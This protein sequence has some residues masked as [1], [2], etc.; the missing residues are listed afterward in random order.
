MLARALASVELAAGWALHVVAVFLVR[1]T[2]A[3]IEVGSVTGA[4]LHITSAQWLA[5]PVGLAEV[6]ALWAFEV[7][8]LIDGLALAGVLVLLKAKEAW[9]LVGALLLW[10]ALAE[11]LVPVGIVGAVFL[12]ALAVV[13][14]LALTLV[15]V[16]LQA[17]EVGA[18]LL[19]SIVHGHAIAPLLVEEGAWWAAVNLAP[20]IAHGH[21][22]AFLEVGAHHLLLGAVHVAV[23]L[24]NTLASPLIEHGA[25]W[26]VLPHE[27][28]LAT[29]D[30]DA[31]AL[32]EVGSDTVSLEALN[33]AVVDAVADIQVPIRIAWALHDVITAPAMY[34]LTVIVVDVVALIA[35]DVAFF[36]NEASTELKVE[37]GT[38]WAVTRGHSAQ[39]WHAV[40]VDNIKSSIL[41]AFHV[42]VVIWQALT[43]RVLQDTPWF[44]IN[45]TLNRFF[46]TTVFLIDVVTL[47]APHFVGVNG[48]AHEHVTVGSW[49]LASVCIL[50]RAKVWV[51]LAVKW[52]KF[53]TFCAAHF[54]FM[55]F[56]DANTTC[57]RLQ[58]VTFV[59]LEIEKSGLLWA[60]AISRIT[61]G[62]IPA[63]VL[64]ADDFWAATIGWIAAR[65]IPAQICCAIDWL[66]A[67]AVGWIAART[68]PA[69]VPWAL[70]LL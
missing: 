59:T 37:L 47:W 1:L 33:I 27:R 6:G 67:A 13:H 3:I 60:A 4:A 24:Q 46:A 62:A 35:P 23:L 20:V 42:T 21:A 18:L 52:I 30:R 56:L 57:S 48:W 11:L 45:I 61:A 58:E 69:E 2:G 17:K 16:E 40:A 39:V 51:A 32:L 15:L 9:A 41:W 7:L 43:G 10:H 50:L 66:W 28:A 34:A 12:H 8:L 22:L 36:F 63:E 49:V 53:E 68:I 55:E 14:W 65:T 26:A 29:T 70:N 54:T 25:A 5:V 31:L 44:T 64:S 19:A 38:V